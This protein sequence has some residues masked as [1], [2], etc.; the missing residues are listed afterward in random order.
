MKSNRTTVKKFA[1][2]LPVLVVLFFTAGSRLSFHQPSE[3]HPAKSGRG[4]QPTTGGTVVIGI[5]QDFDSFNE[6]NASDADALQIINEM[7]FMTLTR[8]DE[9]LNLVPY[10]AESWA[11]SDQGRV[12][13]YHLRRDI[14]WSDGEPTTARDVLFTYQMASDSA[15]AYP[16]A[17][18]FDMTREVRLLDDYT[19]QFIFKQPYPDALFDTKIPILPQHILGTVPAEEINQSF[20]NRSP[21]GNGP[22]VLKEWKANHHAI[23]EANPD[24]APGRPK[25]DRVIFS[26]QP[27][28]N[29]M[30]MNFKTGAVD[31]LPYVS[32]HTFKS[33]SSERDVQLFR[34]ASKSYSFLAW[35]CRRPWLTAAV[36]HALTH[37]INK[38]EFI[39]TLLEGYAEPVIGPILPFTSA[40]DST[41]T[42][43]E[44]DPQEAKRLLR[45]EG[46]SD[47]DNDGYLDNGRRRLEITIKTNA[48]TQLRKDVAVMIQAQL[49][50]IGV[51]VSVQILDFNL[52]LEQVFDQGDFD[53]MLA[54]WDVDFT[55]NPV[56]LFHSKS[57][58]GGY[59][60]VGYTN[61]RVD[62]LLEQ[63][64][65]IVDP[66]IALPVW[67]EFQR[68]IL[69]DCPYTFLFSKDNL[70]VSQSRLRG[71]T[72]D[73][74]GF[75]AG[76]CNWWIGSD[77]S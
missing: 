60:F 53:A 48:G 25:L 54:G 23:F 38:R 61:P 10:L 20:F 3:G 16:A 72:L 49:K 7:L 73:V 63:G 71:V 26:V 58:T 46:W 11:F 6:L 8:L 52:L 9:S 15:V 5:Q 14:T 43:L 28:E 36:R 59:N 1:F 69:K 77:E 76:V 64:R 45:Q 34:Y 4:R 55:V 41:L 66:A 42:D 18:R 65:S 31:L 30:M 50:K 21:V 67:S 74:R 70:A 32:T 12:L 35:N 47:S 19:V 2:F 62:E 39:D 29:V 51:Y 57:I 37:A 27:D 75:L 33:L 22:F 56:A 44:Y 13:T 17:D 40:F 68:L 24:F